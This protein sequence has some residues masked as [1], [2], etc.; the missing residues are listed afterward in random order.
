MA[1]IRIFTFRVSFLVVAC[2]AF[3]GHPP[4]AESAVINFDDAPDGT[5]INTRYPGVTFSNPVGGNIFARS[6]FGAAPSSPNVASVIG[7]GFPQFN[8][9]LGAVDAT[10]ATPVGS[11]SIDARPSAPVEFLGALTRRPFLQAFDASGALLTTVLYAGPLPTGG[12]AVGPTETLSFISTGNNIS[13]VRFS[14]QTP[15]CPVATTPP[16]YGFFDNLRFDAL[17]TLSAN[18]TGNGSV[19]ASPSQASYVDGTVVTLTATPQAGWR[20]LNWSG[21]AGGA[22]NPLALTINGN[23]S[24]T[25][26]FVPVNPTP[27]AS[28][29]ADFNSGAPSGVQLFGDAQVDGGHLKLHS[30]GQPRSFGVAYINDF[31][32]GQPVGGFHATFKAAL[33]GST[34]CGGGFYP[35][36]GFSFNLVPAITALVNPTYNEPG[37]EGLSD[38][39]AVTFDTWDNGDFEA[40]AIEVKWLGQIIASA[41]FQSSQSPAGINDPVAASRDVVIHLDTDGTIDVS[42]GG[43]TVLSDVQTPYRP[44]RIGVPKWVFGARVGSANDNHWIDDLCIRTVAGGKLC[45]DF[46]NDVPA[47]TTLFGN[48]QVDDGRLKLYTIPQDGGFGIAYFDDFSEGH[49]VKAFRATFKAAL[50]GSTCCGG[51]GAFPA[52]GFSFN[53]VPATTVLTNPGYNEPGE[54]GL[55]QGL[56]VNFDTWDNGFGEA[57][58]I[59]IKWL[60]Q[61]IATAPFQSS[62]SPAGITDA[63]A[64]SRDVIIELKANGRMDVSYGGTLVLNNVQTPYDPAAIRTPK[65]ILG[66]R[67]GGAND[68]HWFDDLCITTL[69]AP[70]LH[71]IPG[72]FNTGVD[73]AGK[74]LADNAVDSHYRLTFGGSTA[75]VATEA[76]GFPIPPWLGSNSMSAWITPAPDTL[77]LSDGLGTYNYRYETT[78]DLTG[79][80]A[81]S[82]RIAGRWATDNGG[83]DILINGVS[84]GQPNSNQFAN[85]T[86]FQITS[87]LI[88][89]TNRL[90]F[91]VNNGGP[92][93][94]PGSDPTGLR[95]ELWGEG[96]LHC[97]AARTVPD[98]RISRRTG[99]VLL[100]WSQTGYVVQGARNVTG[101]WADL[102]RGSSINGVDH[103]A[104]FSSGHP[105]QFFRLR[106]A[107]GE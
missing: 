24:V 55:D 3:L 38:G 7:A 50:F 56:S 34:C 102:T 63:N 30:V 39:L 48:A 80:F 83:V 98:I 26:N 70:G 67:I 10:F 33:F 100:S 21:A 15:G 36:D 8:A 81:A 54:E 76:G 71:Q 45:H 107:C 25:A 104:T 95:V 97:L 43:V 17:R 5:V 84:T 105:H 6:G 94:S 27:E 88:A 103:T 12:G 92:G 101:P 77:G 86:P 73:A 59:E 23:T 74:P 35:A 93:S 46:N 68:N 62:Q 51:A 16:V 13:R 72:L 75:Y 53:L 61:I 106:F 4:A 49:F 22:V 60:G 99:N 20:F 19:S 89:G 44:A 11:V 66:A 31:N 90:T 2:V 9:C 18:V 96:A 69:P 42:Y 87:G 82:A 79:F 41:P 29:C 28:F 47:G 78:F 64:A 37:E 40:P 32:G 52:D 58:A 57:P 14:T 85:W 1:F 65:W 91:I